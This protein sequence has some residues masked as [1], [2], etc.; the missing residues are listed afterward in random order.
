MA[1]A[2]IGFG[3]DPCVLEAN[4]VVVGGPGVGKSN[5]AKSLVAGCPD[6]GGYRFEVV[7]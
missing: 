1:S 5:L 4:V 7:E 6:G 2:G 3:F